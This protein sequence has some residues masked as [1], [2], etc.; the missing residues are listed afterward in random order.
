MY[1]TGLKLR[2]SMGQDNFIGFGKDAR[3]WTKDR[4]SKSQNSGTDKQTNTMNTYDNCSQCMGQNT[5]WIQGYFE[6]KPHS[7]FYHK[8]IFTNMGCFVE[9]GA[10]YL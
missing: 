2:V 7:S 6:Q 5:F 3:E 8:P 10:I 9:I 4:N 1:A